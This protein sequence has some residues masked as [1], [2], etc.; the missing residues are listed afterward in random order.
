MRCC[1][2]DFD[3][4]NP[5]LMSVGWGR[6]SFPQWVILLFH[7]NALGIGPKHV[8]LKSV[9]PCSFDLVL[10][11]FIGAGCAVMVDSNWMKTMR[12]AISSHV[13]EFCHLGVPAVSLATTAA[14]SAVGIDVLA[15]ELGGHAGDGGGEFLDLRLH[16]RQFVCC[17]DVGHCVGCVV[18][19]ACAG[20]LLDVLSDLIAVV[21]HLIG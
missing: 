7:C 12:A 10:G 16:R 3:A 15:V 9:A 2:V 20:E 4:C 21:C 14:V 5:Q 1:V 11:L 17:L 6:L 18:G 19:C 13:S 8:S